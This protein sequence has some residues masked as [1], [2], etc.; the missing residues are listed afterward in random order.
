MKN[1][2]FALAAAGLALA[3]PAPGQPAATN[4]AAMQWHRPAEVR[5]TVTDQAGRVVAPA[6]LPAQERRRVTSL[7]SSLQNW[8]NQ[9]GQR[10]SVTINCT[11]PPLRCE[12]TISF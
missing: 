2:L 3:G 6:S 11:W 7:Q 4:A 1:S 5:L 10:V 12:I 9:Q 8:G